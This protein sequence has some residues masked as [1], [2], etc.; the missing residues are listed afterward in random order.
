M[1]RRLG[2]A[3]LLVLVGALVT[4]AA[5]AAVRY[6]AKSGGCSHMTGKICSTAANC[7]ATFDTACCEIQQGHDSSQTASGDT[8]EIHAGTYTQTGA[9]V[10]AGQWY[11][12]SVPFSARITKS[13]LTVK[14][15]AGETYTMDLQ[16]TRYGGLWI[17]AD[18]VTVDGARCV[19]QL[20]AGDS[21]RIGCVTFARN[22]G[23]GDC[24][25]STL[26]NS[27]AVVAESTTDPGC[28]SCTVGF[29]IQ[30]TGNS[31]VYNNTIT[32]AF[33]TGMISMGSGGA[34]SVTDIH[35]NTFTGTRGGSGSQTCIIE[36][37]Q[38]AGATYLAHDNKCTV[39]NNFSASRF[40]YPR[41]ND[42]TSYYFNNYASGMQYGFYLQDADDPQ[43]ETVYIFGNTME[44]CS[45]GMYWYADSYRA[46]IRN[47]IFNCGT[48]VRFVGCGG[49][50]AGTGIGTSGDTSDFRNN[51]YSSTLKVNSSGYPEPLGLASLNIPSNCSLD[52]AHRLTSGSTACLDVGYNNPIDKGVNTCLISGVSCLPDMDGDVRPK[53]VGFDLGADERTTTGGGGAV[54]GN[55]TTET[56]EL[57]DDGNTVTETACPYGTAA[58]TLCNATCSARLVL[59]GPFCGDGIVN[60]AEPCDGTHLNGHTCSEFGCSSGTPQCLSCVVVNTGCSSCSGAA[61]AERPWAYDDADTLGTVFYLSS[62]D[63]PVG[64]YLSVFGDDFGAT[65][66]NG[67]VTVGGTAASIVSWSA[68]KIVITVPNVATGLRPIAVTPNGGAASATYPFSVNSGRIRHLNVA[69]SSGGNG[70]AS[71]PWNTFQAADAGALPGDHII[72]HAGTYTRSP[73]GSVDSNWDSAKGGTSGNSITWYAMP[74]DLVT[75]DGTSVLKTAVRL[76]AP[77]VNVVGVVG[78]GSLFQNFFTDSGGTN[79]RIVDCES[80]N[81]NGV[82][83]T[84][85]QGINLTGSGSEAIGNYVHNNYSH[86]FYVHANAL[87]IAYN[88]VA[89]SGCCGAPSSYGYGIQLYLTDP[90]PTFT[91]DKVFRNFVTTSNRSGIV[92]GQYAASTDVYENVVTGNKERGIIVNYTASSTTI[93]NNTSYRN[94]TVGAGFYEIDLFQGV[95]ATVYNNAVTGPNGM[96]RRSA[97]TGTVTIN[98]N[99]YDGASS[100]S[101]NGTNYSS[102]SSWRTG[103]GQDSSSQAA[104]AMY[105]NAAALDFCPATGSPMIDTGNDAQCART[106]KGAHCDVGAFEADTTG[107]DTVPPKTPTNLH[108]D[109]RH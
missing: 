67:G 79:S 80:K 18:G 91:G 23:M 36:E 81:G 47:N 53:G 88:Y 70:T 29:R 2:P 8:L 85:G 27:T 31:A 52:A 49:P 107:T 42:A 73:A 102:L 54:C 51:A 74:G 7:G 32:G 92:V 100:W 72:V 24:A 14:V 3:G 25:N 21:V 37:H 98:S 55:G 43:N 106:F 22:A 71:S 33:G 99:L 109:D 13:S 68:K 58:C 86:G 64:S 16:T 56:G 6:V 84:K 94:D 50:C 108:R 30:M 45:F 83:S 96:I 63:G 77:Y 93:R 90:G 12:N 35:H 59:T 17:D 44:N 1:V 76:S 48:A 28:L 69:S 5:S 15:A 26:K 66:G 97:L 104:N 103:S 75:V 19:N 11:A 101:W 20:T 61:K 87:K 9:T 78:T 65:R 4:P 40:A 95:G 82:V 46:H 60:G 34:G 105:R 10:A 89:D 62:T 39:T 41:D 57:C 38:E